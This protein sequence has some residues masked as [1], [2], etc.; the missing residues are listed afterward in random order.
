[1]PWH[2]TIPRA[3]QLVID[4]V[5][6]REGWRLDD[7]GG[8][9]RAGIDRLLGPADYAAIADLG[10][11]LGIRPTAAMV[12][13]EWDRENVCARQPTC[14]Q[15][16]AAW[17]NSARAGAW[18]DEAARCFAERAAHIELALHG[19][20]HEHWDDGR[21]TRAEYYAHGQGKWRW[22][23]LQGHLEVFRAILDQHGLGP[24]AG[25]R[26]P[27]HFIP[28]AFAYLLDEADDTDTGALVAS[29]GCEWCSTPFGALTQRTPLPAATGGVNH[30]VLIVDR[31]NNG[32]PWYAVDQVPAQIMGQVVDEDSP[33]LA[34]AAAVAPRL[35]AEEVDLLLARRP[36]G[37]AA[38]QERLVAAHLPLAVAE[39]R[40]YL[41]HGLNAAGLLAAAREGLE[42]AV[43]TFAVA[44]GLTFETWAEL[45]VR[46]AV[47]QAL[48]AADVPAPRP[49]P[50]APGFIC[51]IHWPN[52]LAADPA[53]ND[54]AVGH[55]RAHL[56]QVGAQSGQMLAGNAREAFA[57]WAWHTFGRVSGTDDGF[58][59]DMSAVPPDVRAAVG[60][61]PVIVEISGAQR[62]G[63]VVAGELRPVWYRRQG[64][65]SFVAVQVD[66]DGGRVAFAPSGP[67]QPVVL[68]EDGANVL[69]LTASAEGL[70]LAV[71]V[72]GTQTVPLAPGFAP[73]TVEVAG[74]GL[75]L[76]ERRDNPAL[77]VMH[78]RLRARDAQGATGRVQ[79]HRQP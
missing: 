41:G 6:W 43:Q 74:G 2:V 34:E 3:V 58:V 49:A 27:R 36:L 54:V 32:V 20:G 78:L 23:D 38:D 60:A 75:E 52:L 42:R 26:L 51:G 24:A 35:S 69:D 76:V 62:L 40:L 72:F 15:A 56:E 22:E 57:Q 46:D 65:R 48:A 25:H 47:E 11:A 64:N 7:Q 53:E 66:G 37:A 19:V 14:T 18:S 79:I 4:D 1:M 33:L 16:G 8:P 28:C 55:W 68:R 71:E 5:G 29:A 44:R 13:C 39:A 59:L 31:G 73:G 12:L 9:Y 70:E 17:D 77:G 30:G 67:L 50:I 10:Q 45:A 61:M 21:I 63:R